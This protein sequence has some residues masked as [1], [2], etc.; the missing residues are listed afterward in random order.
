M[1][2]EEQK[3]VIIHVNLCNDKK[4]VSFLQFLSYPIRMSIMNEQK[5][6]GEYTYKSNPWKLE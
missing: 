1:I 6:A 2:D 5:N 4:K 3:G